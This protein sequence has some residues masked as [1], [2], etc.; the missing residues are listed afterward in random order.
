M[1]S[2]QVPIIGDYLHNDPTMLSIS[3]PDDPQQVIR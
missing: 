3:F 2:A 1:L